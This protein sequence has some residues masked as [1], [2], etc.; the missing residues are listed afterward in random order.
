MKTFGFLDLWVNQGFGS[1]PEGHVPGKL[2]DLQGGKE[3][4]HGLSRTRFSR[5]TDLN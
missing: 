2:E 3:G 5:Y 1:E 4:E